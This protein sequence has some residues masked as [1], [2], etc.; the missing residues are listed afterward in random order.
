MNCRVRADF[1]TP[2]LPTMITLCRARELWFL[3]LLV[4]MS[5]ALC[6]AS[7]THLHAH[8]HTLVH[9]IGRLHTLTA[10][11]EEKRGNISTNASR[12]DH[13]CSE[14]WHY[15]IN[16]TLLTVTW[17]VPELGFAPTNPETRDY[18]SKCQMAHLEPLNFATF[19]IK[20]SS[21]PIIGNY[22]TAAECEMVLWNTLK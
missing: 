11:A 15:V 17:R 8:S 19:V 5:G 4:A 21:Q 6:R 14:R 3:P 16:V 12:T 7:Y 20:S 10:P 9:T 22:A 13:R 2:P 1:P 18:I